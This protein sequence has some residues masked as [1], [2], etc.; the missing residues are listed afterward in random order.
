M[1]N[2]T[3]N[4]QQGGKFD[5]I[6]RENMSENYPSIVEHVLGLEVTTLEELKDDIQYTKE[7][8]T[9][10][11]KKVRDKQGNV[12]ILHV[13]FQQ[14]NQKRKMVF[15]MA[16]YSIMLQRKYK[17]PVL[18]YVIYIGQGKANMI[19]AINSKDLQFRYNLIAL[20][21]IDYKLFLKS[22]KIEEKMLAILGNL[23]HKSPD[24]LLK[25]I[26][27]TIKDTAVDELSAERYVKQLHVLVQLRNFT[28]DLETVM[29]AIGSFFKIEKDPFYIKGQQAATERER[30]KAKAALAKAEQEKK[31]IAI[32]MARK[33]L[34]AKEPLGK[35]T[36]YTGLSI[37]EIEVL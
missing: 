10:L 37:T 16:E 24:G 2:Q 26:L 3:S 1:L 35:I 15:R 12:F 27:L 32:Q 17:L 20:S 30:A 21:S 22:D 5:K 34:T 7:R 9:D 11:L 23:N 8:E 33:M 36:E 6:F 13:E 18:Q 25:Q 29:E 31:E 4:Y 19:N 14:S 28:T